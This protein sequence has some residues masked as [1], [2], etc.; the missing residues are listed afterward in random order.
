MI[1]LTKNTT[2]FGLMAPDAQEALRNHPGPI[3]VWYSIEGWLQNPD[4]WW[5][6]S[7]VYRVKPQPREWWN[8]E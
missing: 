2:P 3:E 6:P 1:D 8:E 4:P 5:T 7:L